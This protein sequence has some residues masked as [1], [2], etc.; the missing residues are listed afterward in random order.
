MSVEPTADQ[1][2]PAQAASTATS[3]SSPLSRLFALYHK[4]CASAGVNDL[5]HFSPSDLQPASSQRMSE[6]TRVPQVYAKRCSQLISN[7]KCVSC[8]LVHRCCI[9]NIQSKGELRSQVITPAVDSVSPLASAPQAAPQ[10]APACRSVHIVLWLHHMEFGRASNTGKLLER[11]DTLKFDSPNSDGATIASPRVTREM[12]L[13]GLPLSDAYID[14]LCNAPDA[15]R[16]VAV[17]FPDANAITP[18]ELVKRH[19]TTDAELE[20]QTSNTAVDQVTPHNSATQTESMNSINQASPP[21]ATPLTIIVVDAT[22]RLARRMRLR[23]PKHIRS[24][25]IRPSGAAAAQFTDEPE[26]SQHQSTEDNNNAIDVNQLAMNPRKGLDPHRFGKQIPDR[27]KKVRKAVAEADA[28]E[29][30]QQQQSATPSD[31]FTSI[32]HSLRAQSEEGRCSTLE[33]ILFLLQELHCSS[34]LISALHQRLCILVDVVR[35]QNCLYT[36]HGTLT[37]EQVNQ[38]RRE[39][40][41][42][43]RADDMDTEEVV[44]I[45]ASVRPRIAQVPAAQRLCDLYNRQPLGEH[46]HSISSASTG[47]P[48]LSARPLSQAHAPCGRLQCKYRH[49]CKSCGAEQH[50]AMQCPK[51]PTAQ[52]FA[53]QLNLAASQSCQSSTRVP[54]V[55]SV[56]PSEG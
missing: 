30:E 2:A 10:A 9:C 23:L 53:P 35:I 31:S 25:S 11:F 42:G 21:A 56:M 26:Q 5:R 55:Q 54:L 6:T 28:E 45:R 16:N 17:L 39:T 51:N 19:L 50:G 38:M 14:Q 34:H 24:V 43:E 12:V 29:E 41:K 44:A 46:P 18:E 40:S 32:F 1:S 22:W 15:H 48:A 7:S 37:P 4:Q 3:D 8:W 27:I 33:A 47:D 36:V 52:T 49:A 13:Y 20:Q